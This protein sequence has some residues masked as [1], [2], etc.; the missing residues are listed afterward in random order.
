MRTFRVSVNRPL[1]LGR[2]SDR[3]A[4]AALFAFGAGGYVVGGWA[5]GVEAGLAAY[6]TWAVAREL[7]PDYPVSANLSAL[8]GGGLALALDTH[9]GVLFV[10]LLVVKVMV[11]SSGLPPATWEAGVLGLVA[12]VFAGTQTG[13]W[14]GMAMAAALFLDT[15]VHPSASPAHRWIAGA[16]G[17]GASL[18]YLF[19]GDH[20][21]WWSVHVPAVTAAGLVLSVRTAYFAEAHGRFV[22]RKRMLFPLWLAGG[23]AG[24]QLIDRVADLGPGDGSRLVYLLL[25][26]GS[27]L[28]VA[29]GFIRT[30]VESPTDHADHN[31]SSERVDIARC[32][33]VAFVI[34]AWAS[35][36][37]ESVTEAVG[38]AAPLLAMIVLIA[39]RGLWQR[40]RPRITRTQ[41]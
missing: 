8:A 40:A 28:G 12:V 39:L 22:T 10:M 24:I 18:F 19:L 26:A 4:L 32:L 34:V 1:D 3:L 23:P 21:L 29:V 36:S 41:T 37:G 6:L 2:P 17:V 25:V 33:M 13:W 14:A 9:A 35:G 20:D 27:A 11:G 15:A 38:P 30:K 5:E 31:I 7:D 16:V